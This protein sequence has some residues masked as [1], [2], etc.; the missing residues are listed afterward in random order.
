MASSSYSGY[1]GTMFPAKT[2]TIAN[3]QQSSSVIA[4]DG[5][6]LVGIYLPAA[7]TGTALTFEACDTAAG[8]FLPVKAGTGGSALSYTVAQGTFVAI[9]P[10]DFQGIAFLKIKSGS[11]EGAARTLKCALKGL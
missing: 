7:F 2:V 11:A 5:F 8:T 1:Q 9:D 4:L 3:G 10:K 6:A